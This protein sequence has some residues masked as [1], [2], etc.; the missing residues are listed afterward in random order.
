MIQRA[1]LPHS[2]EA[3]RERSAEDRRLQAVVWRVMQRMVKRA[4]AVGFHIWLGHVR[5][6]L[7]VVHLES[8][9]WGLEVEG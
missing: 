2:F 7:Q 3:W 1:S 8:L 5:E 9:C 4:L 6:A